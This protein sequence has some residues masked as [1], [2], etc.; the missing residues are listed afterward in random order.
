MISVS[1]IVKGLFVDEER[2]RNNK[3]KI[4][5]QKF[6]IFFHLKCSA[7]ERIDVEVLILL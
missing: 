2:K 1:P 5:L 7:I 4:K 3:S 6:N